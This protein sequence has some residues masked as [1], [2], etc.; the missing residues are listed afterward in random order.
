[1]LKCCLDPFGTTQSIC[2]KTF[3]VKPQSSS[4]INR[5]KG[6]CISCYNTAFG[7][8]LTSLFLWNLL[9]VGLGSSVGFQKNLCGLLVREF[10]PPRCP[11]CHPTNIVK[12]VSFEIVFKYTEFVALCHVYFSLR[13][14]L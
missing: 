10:L 8:C 6:S 7:L 13:D 1:M 12:A 2:F 14:I 5:V 11:S 3:F 4:R 9:Q